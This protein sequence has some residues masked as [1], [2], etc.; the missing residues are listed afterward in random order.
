MLW[1]ATPYRVTARYLASIIGDRE[2]I[3]YPETVRL[4]DTMKGNIM[5]TTKTSLCASIVSIKGKGKSQR[6]AAYMAIAPLAFVEDVSRSQ[7][8]ANLRVALGLSPTDSERDAAKRQWVIGRVASRLPAGELPARDMASIDK[9]DFASKI[10]TSYAAPAK[11]GAKARKLRA[12]QTGR[13]T[14]T[15]HRVIRNAEEAWS[16]V[17][18]ELALGN[19]KTQGERNAAKAK[20]APQMAGSSKSA[21][22]PTHSQ[23]VKAAIPVDANE[24]CAMMLQLATSAL[25]Y[26]NKHAKLLPTD[27]GKAAGAFKKAI[28]AADKARAEA[29]ALAD[30]KAAE[31]E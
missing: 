7:S 2:A 8:I 28:I 6:E 25:G 14:A 13:R 17:A 1:G 10:V 15:Q 23:L 11:E 21:T 19:A 4:S 3:R 12:G 30:A 26:V 31:A 27:Y 16:Q 20:R 22:P 24:A 5:T 18:A 29:T 9:L